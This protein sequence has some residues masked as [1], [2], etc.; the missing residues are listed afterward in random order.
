MRDETAGEETGLTERPPRSGLVQLL[1]E[2]PALPAGYPGTRE[3]RRAKSVAISGNKPHLVNLFFPT[4][5]ALG[6]GI[7]I[8]ARGVAL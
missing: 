1:S 8:S 7:Q 5:A 6:R 2:L 3:Q 4:N